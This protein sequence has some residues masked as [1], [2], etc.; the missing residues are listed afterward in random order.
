ETGDEEVVLAVVPAAGYDEGLLRKALPAII[1]AA[2]L[3]D[4]VEP[5]DAFPR[6]GRADKL[7]RAG[8]VPRLL[9]HGG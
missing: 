2:A 5:L 7:D 8:R 1:D 6:S 3:P 9:R 4:R